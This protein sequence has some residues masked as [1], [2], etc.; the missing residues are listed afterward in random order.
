MLRTGHVAFG[1]VLSV[2]LRDGAS[3]H[4]ESNHIVVPIE[5]QNTAIVCSMER[6]GLPSD[7]I[8]RSC[9]SDSQNVITNGTRNVVNRN[10]YHI[11]K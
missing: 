11:R 10:V 5:L 6:G 2:V 3:A 4:G 9:L 8:R 7:V 1:A